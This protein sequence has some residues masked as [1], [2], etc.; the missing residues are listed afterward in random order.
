MEFYHEPV[1]L[2][3]V[4]SYLNPKP[5]RHFID[6]TL[7]GGGHASAILEKTGPTGALIGFD[8]D[9]IAIAY[10]KKR[11][12]KFKNRA[13]L[14]QDS[15]LNIKSYFDGKEIKIAP[16]GILLD[17]GLS[18]RQLTADDQRGFSFKIDAPLDMRFGPDA[19]RTAADIVNNSSEQELLRIIKDF[20]EE[21]KAKL[22]AGKIVS[23]RKA[24]P[25]KT[26]LQ[27]LEIIKSCFKGRRFGKTHPA[28]KTFQALRIAV[29]RELDVLR[30]ALP[31]LISILPKKGKLAI[32]SYHSLEDRIVKNFF[33][34]KARDCV[35]PPSFPVCQCAHK[36][37]IKITTKKPIIATEREI[38]NNPRSRSAKLRVAEKI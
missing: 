4:L 30:Q 38:K 28:T 20:G 23:A 37:E 29:N 26:V 24:S 6:G 13:I 25:I 5:N 9:P 2:N 33:K 10:A 22:I 7:G 34:E 16:D 8:R 35:C 36:P 11:L 12:A 14:F 31:L 15:Y 1:L 27:L 3:E 32:I 18:S 21:P 19:K 17:L